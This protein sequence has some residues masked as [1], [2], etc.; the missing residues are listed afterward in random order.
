MFRYFKQHK[1]SEAQAKGL[2]NEAV[3]QS[4]LP[5]F[6][7]DLGV[8]DSF[9]GRFE[10]VA[11]HCY[12]II[13]RLNKAGQTRLSQALFDV[14]FIS[15]DQSIREMGIGD[16]GVPKHMKRMMQGFNGRC[17]GYEIAIENN[18]T[19]ALKEA[20]IRN[21]YGTSETSDDFS[22]STLSTYVEQS[23]AMDTTDAEFAAININQEGVEYA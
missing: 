20:L 11:L 13:H 16:V 2:Y 9:D 1:S 12:M 14:F 4:R 15:M 3:T 22:V 6:Y 23:C 10:L 18:D 17:Q 8:P 5:V 7:Q 21:V 19:T